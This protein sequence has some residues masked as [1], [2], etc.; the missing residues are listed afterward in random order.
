ML[1]KKLPI[2]KI[3]T[4][5]K[6]VKLQN[7]TGLLKFAIFKVLKCFQLIKRCSATLSGVEQGCKLLLLLK[8]L[9]KRRAF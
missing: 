8:C 2:Q 3:S 9:L 1:V 5:L 6:A 4:T 7:N